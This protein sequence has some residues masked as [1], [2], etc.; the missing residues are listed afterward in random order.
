MGFMSGYRDDLE[1]ARHRIE[2]LE[3][4]LVER[5]ASL[6]A[7]EA[8]L[9][10]QRAELVR[11]RRDTAGAG[12]AGGGT[13]DKTIVLAIALSV[14]VLGMVGAALVVWRVNSIEDV[15]V[16]PPAQPPAPIVQPVSDPPKVAETGAVPPGEDAPKP[17]EVD[18]IQDVVHKARPRVKMCYE[19]ELAR[20]PDAS[21]TTTVTL[22]ILEDGNVQQVQFEPHATI[23]SKAL[24]ECIKRVYLELRFPKLASTTKTRIPL[25]FFPTK[26][27]LGF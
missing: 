5:D 7:R 19:Q 12:T 26:H 13:K 22:T 11:A 25:T 24:D 17:S 27:D 6:H 4:K 9:A 8:E 1:A 14:F 10:E 2:T 23:S 16:Q 15:V 18:L 20:D 21:G 3:A